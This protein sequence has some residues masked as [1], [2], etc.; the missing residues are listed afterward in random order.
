MVTIIS[1]P[2]IHEQN[3]VVFTIVTV[4]YVIAAHVTVDHHPCL[5]APL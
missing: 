5:V 3:Q 1:Y 4:P 2:K